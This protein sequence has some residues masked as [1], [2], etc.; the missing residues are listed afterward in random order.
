MRSRPANG[1]A[2]KQLR[3]NIA[4]DVEALK[5]KAGLTE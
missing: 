4:V 1:W 2:L 3:E 5:R